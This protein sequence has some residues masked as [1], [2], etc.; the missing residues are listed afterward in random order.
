[1]LL[2][3]TFVASVLSSQSESAAIGWIKIYVEEAGAYVLD[4]SE[5]R[6]LLEPSGA[7]EARGLRISHRGRSL[8]QWLDESGGR[9]I[10]TVPRSVFA[11]EVHHEE[12]RLAALRLDVDVEGTPLPWSD[13]PKETVA[14]GSATRRVRLEE[15]QLLAP[16]TASPTWE[17]PTLWHWALLS[18]RSSSE[19]RIAAPIPRR[20]LR[21][22]AVDLRVRLLGWS[23]PQD[24]EEADH[25]VSISVDGVVVGS[26]SWNGRAPFELSVE[27]LVV[28]SNRLGD[29]GTPEDDADEVTLRLKV[30]PRTNAAGREIVDLSYVDWIEIEY[31][32]GEYRSRSQQALRLASA[33][34]QARRWTSSS[35]PA[36]EG[37]QGQR[38]YVATFGPDDDGVTEVFAATAEQLLRPTDLAVVSPASLDEDAAP[39]A[40]YL[41]VA[42][43]QFLQQAGRLAAL[44]EARGLEALVV[45]AHQIFDELGDGLR[46][47]QPL[48]DY[49]LRRHRR[50]GA[51]RWVLLLGDADWYAPDEVPLEEVSGHRNLLPSWTYLSR[52]GPAVSDHYYAV[53]SEDEST[54]RFALGRLPVATEQELKH[55]VDK[56]ERFLSA[57]PAT[58]RS[59]LLLGSLDSPSQ[60][61]LRRLR[62]RWQSQAIREGYA[63]RALERSPATTLEA[64]LLSAWN[65]DPTVVYFSGHGSRHLW[66]LGELSDPSPSAQWNQEVAATTDPSPRPPVVLSISCAT[67]PF[68]HPNNSSLGE[69]LVLDPDGGAIGFFGASATLYTLPRFGERLLSEVTAGTSLGESLVRAKAHASDGALS[70]LYN[71][72]GDPALSLP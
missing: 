53:E 66:R 31:P 56:I 63:L 45:D 40:E 32:L 23:R 41:I 29:E 11:A 4:L 13:Q 47:P 49:L 35:P 14:R 62:R 38:L 26:G 18:Q 68:D 65:E 60:G 6:E 72:L 10:F 71:L 61:R 33:P 58:T 67:A 64:E 44:H 42:P 28:A 69:A 55:A 51:L 59:A 25:T 22:G 54:P 52:F 24:L 46:R 43:P 3:L 16:L 48:R 34:G 37:Q 70:H 7:L 30:P 50:H 20:A 2:V 36:L 17:S 27:N 5:V 15:N 9:L 39:Q 8:P 21:D 1:M 19:L 57:A 12:S